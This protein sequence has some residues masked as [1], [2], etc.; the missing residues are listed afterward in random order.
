MEIRDKLDLQKEERKEMT[1]LNEKT[2]TESEID[3]QLKSI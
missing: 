2:K 1:E 3:N